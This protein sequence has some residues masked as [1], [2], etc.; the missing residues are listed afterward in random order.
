MA[1]ENGSFSERLQSVDW[2][3]VGIAAGVGFAAGALA[4]IVATTTLAAAVLGATA[5]VTQYGLTQWSNQDSVTWGGAAVNVGIG[6]LTGGLISGPFNVQ[7][8][9]Y[10][11]G[12]GQ[13]W[14]ASQAAWAN[15]GLQI[16]GLLAAENLFRSSI[17]EIVNNLDFIR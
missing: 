11:Y 12:A 8:G 5:N 7:P 13:Q 6:A 15:E 10:S 16:E 4:P 14:T 17:S 3:N 9:P 2:G 1:Q